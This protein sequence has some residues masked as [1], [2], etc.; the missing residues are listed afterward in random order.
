M[1]APMLLG[2]Y[3]ALV[4]IR[5]DIGL[6]ILMSQINISLVMFEKRLK[7]ATKLFCMAKDA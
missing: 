1:A 7:S 5:A 4:L 2:S 6:V 3:I